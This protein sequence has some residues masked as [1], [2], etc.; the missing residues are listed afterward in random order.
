MVPN[1]MHKSGVFDAKEFANFK[2]E[3]IMLSPLLAEFLE[4]YDNFF[5]SKCPEHIKNLASIK[6]TI[7]SSHGYLYYGQ[8]NKYNKP[9][10][11]GFT[12]KSVKG[13]FKFQCGIIDA[14]GLYIG[15]TRIFYPHTG[16]S[17][18]GYLLKN[19]KETFG[20]ETDIKGNKYKGFFSGDV[21]SGLGEIKDV[22]S[23]YDLG[24][25]KDGHLEGEVIRRN[26]EGQK[27]RVFYDEGSQN[28]KSSEEFSSASS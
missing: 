7:I 8:V 20:I 21:R 12:V 17:F 24:I 15:R 13:G 10:G 14:Q 28:D 6:A 1:Q 16:E 19:K 26:A 27:S 2:K 11:Q 4:D 5:F 18:L 9:I 23:N 3:A 25:F 22:E